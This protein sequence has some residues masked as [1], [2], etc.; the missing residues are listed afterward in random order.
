MTRFLRRLRARLRYRN[1]ESDLRDE[2]ETHRTMAEEDARG[3]GVPAEAAR[4]EAAR[5]LGN[6]TNARELSRAVW[7]APW[8]ESLWQDVRYGI[9][10]LRANPG[11]TLPALAVLIVTMGPTTGLFTAVE[12]IF[13]RPWPLPDP[14]RIVVVHATQFDDN[15]GALNATNLAAYRYMRER[16]TSIDLVATAGTSEYLG[17]DIDV[18]LVS[19]NYFDVLRIPIAAGRGLLASDDMP[20]RATVAVIGYRMAEREFGSPDQAVGAVIRVADVTFT[21]VG[22]VAPGPADWPLR[23]PPSVR[24]PFGAMAGLRAARPI[25][26]LS[27]VQVTVQLAGRLKAGADLAAADAEVERLMAQFVATHDAPRS[28]VSVTGTEWVHDRTAGRTGQVFALLSAACVLTLLLGCANVGNLQLA[29]GI[30]RGAEIGV[31]QSL[32][33]H[34]RRLVRQLLVESLVLATAGA[35][36]SVVLAWQVA[37]RALAAFAFPHPEL[38]ALNG[39]TLAFVFGLTLLVMLFSGMLPALRV[40]RP[41]SGYRIVRAEERRLRGG[42]LG[43]QVAIGVVLLVSAGLLVRAVQHAGGS[44]LRFDPGRVTTIRPFIPLESYAPAEQEQLGRVV[45]DAASEAG[46][47]PVGGASFAPFTGFRS[48]SEVRLPGE[49]DAANR[50]VVAHQVTAGY[51]EATG[52]PL[53][54]GRLFDAGSSEDDVL[55]NESLARRLWPDQRALGRVFLDRDSERRVIGVVADA[56]TERVEI[57]NPIYY[58]RPGPISYV[59]VRTDQASVAQVLDIIQTV[60]PGSSPEVTTLTAGVREQLELSIVGARVAVAVAFVALLLA[61][62]GTLGTFSYLVS[63]RTREIGVRVA[64][65]ACALDVL[66]LLAAR[67]SWPLVGGLLVGVVGAQVLGSV[68]GGYLYGLSP[69]DPVAYA[70]VL[71]VLALAAVLATLI[72]ARRALSVDP[73]VT[74]R[75]E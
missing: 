63:E 5:R 73:V 40:T 60:V 49:P 26:R 74:L 48:S 71:V 38:L 29:R 18:Q 65:G 25:P 21:V 13:F 72:P 9:R 59:L 44:G 31:R 11:F 34:R 68:L 17:G 23:E 61:A 50:W 32:G 39:R 58:R 45:V 53:V 64:L 27:E 14:E 69:R 12:S 67:V 30:A 7:I 22:V 20:G 43:A 10:G 54:A 8:L 62:V 52:I 6:G 24:V 1:F 70:V 42:L 33:A 37:P 36:V 15:G 4:H 75:A 41:G 19:G 57:Q 28:E 47:G 16:A 55:V 46:V 3:R 51:F 35:I 66:R 2:L 56:R